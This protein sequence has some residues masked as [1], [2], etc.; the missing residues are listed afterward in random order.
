MIDDL[1]R[2]VNPTGRLGIAGMFTATDAAPAPDGGH[3]DGSL[4][5]PC[6]VRPCSFS[7]T[8][9]PRM[10]M[11]GYLALSISRWWLEMRGWLTLVNRQSSYSCG[12]S[13]ST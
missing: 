11:S 8:T 2:L 13:T 1:A 7:R 4:Q 9:A 3:A 5:V 6:A 12:S 10:P